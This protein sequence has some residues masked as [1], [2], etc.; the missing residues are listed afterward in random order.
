MI[1]RS[2]E[3]NYLAALQPA[4]LL[5][6]QKEGQ[7]R[8]PDAM[9]YDTANDHLIIKYTNDGITVTVQARSRG[10]HITFELI[11]IGRH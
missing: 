2:S 3:K 9:E 5:S 4:P 11:A 10:T 7:M 8:V 6:L 1:D